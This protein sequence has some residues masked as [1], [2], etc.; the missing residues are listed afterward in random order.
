MDSHPEYITSRGRE[1]L[2]Y[3]KKYNPIGRYYFQKESKRPIIEGDNAAERMK[4]L[5]ELPSPWPCTQLF[6]LTRTDVHK[7]IH[8][9]LVEYSIPD[10]RYGEIILGFFGYLYGMGHISDEISSVR[11]IR[12]ISV[13]AVSSRKNMAESSTSRYMPLTILNRDKPE[14]FDIFKNCLLQEIKTARYTDDSNNQSTLLFLQNLSLSNIT[15]F[16]SDTS[17]GAVYLKRYA[18]MYRLYT[19][20]MPLLLKKMIVSYLREKETSIP[21]PPEPIVTKKSDELDIF[22]TMIRE[23]SDC[24]E[25]DKPVV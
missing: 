23:Y 13:K 8:N 25:L 24:E 12:N 10:I 19:E 18:T 11:D 17:K 14:C 22:V 7:K 5:I 4:K 16:D 6:S 3:E 9:I 15:R 2:L 20:F 1:A 21:L